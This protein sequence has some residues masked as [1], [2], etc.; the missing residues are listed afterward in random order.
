[1]TISE[2]PS[3]T[4]MAIWG[5]AG[6]VAMTGVLQ[7][8]NGFGL[9]RLSIPFVVGT[10]FTGNRRKATVIGLAF[11]LVGGW[12][13]ALLYFLF[14][15]SIGIFTW[16]LGAVLGFLHGLFLLAAI[17][18][19]IPFFHPR[20]ASSYDEPVARPQL[21]PPGFLGRHYGPGT[22]ASMLLAQS[23]YGA[24]LGV[25]PQIGLTAA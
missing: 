19:V 6:T 18:P 25:L 3:L 16:W 14:F 17:L 7:A 20:M 9:S 4:D 11:Y 21:E 5:L 2:L 13:F 22:P 15:A 1:M 10:M 8:A 24:I 12:I 23:L